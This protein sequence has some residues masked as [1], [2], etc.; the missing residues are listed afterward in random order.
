MDNKDSNPDISGGGKDHLT[1]PQ[2]NWNM[3]KQE[4][5]NIL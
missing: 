2:I 4:K 1:F 3:I 5:F